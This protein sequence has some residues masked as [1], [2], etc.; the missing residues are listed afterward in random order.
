MWPIAICERII[1]FIFFC[2][3]ADQFLQF[4]IMKENVVIVQ[5]LLLY[6]H[7]H[8]YFS[9]QMKLFEDLEGE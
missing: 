4:Y 3:F 8:T 7:C 2:N 9:I 6:V 5:N 1:L